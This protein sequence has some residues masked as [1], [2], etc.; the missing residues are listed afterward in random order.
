MRVPDSLRSRVVRVVVG[1]DGRAVK[2]GHQEI[3]RKPERSRRGLGLLLSKLCVNRVRR[4][5]VTESRDPLL[6]IRAK[7]DVGFNAIKVLKCVAVDL[8]PSQQREVRVVGLQREPR[9][10]VLGRRSDGL[11]GSLAEPA[12]HEKRRLARQANRLRELVEDLRSAAHVPVDHLPRLP[13]NAI[14]GESVE[15]VRGAFLV[16]ALLWSTG[17]AEQQANDDRHR[18]RRK[19][20]EKE[21]ACC[22][23]PE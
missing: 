19:R 10:G 15:A 13:F 16:A 4:C 21:R 6:G 11:D 3:V 7:S 5:R 1:C 14:V 9:L 22:G 8:N 23:S 20:A 17:S 2:R 18:D 12:K